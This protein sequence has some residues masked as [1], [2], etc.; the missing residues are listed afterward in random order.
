MRF[1]LNV[2]ECCTQKSEQKELGENTRLKQTM[3]RQHKIDGNLTTN[4]N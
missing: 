3:L 4:S 2:E 1:K